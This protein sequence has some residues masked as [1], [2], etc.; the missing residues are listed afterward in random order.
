[1]SRHS[2][3]SS[4]VV[5]TFVL[6]ILASRGPVKHPKP[7]HEASNFGKVGPIDSS[8]ALTRDDSEPLRPRQEKA[9]DG[10]TAIDTFSYNG[11]AWTAYEDIARFD[12][13]LVLVSASGTRREIRRYVEATSVESLELNRTVRPF[14]DL[15]S[16]NDVN[17]KQNDVLAERLLQD[18]EPIEE[19]VRDVINMAYGPWDTFLGNVQ[20]NDTMTLDWQATTKNYMPLV[21][22]LEAADG[23]HS[24][25]T[26]DGL[27]GGW[28]PSSRKI[29]RGDVDTTD[30]IEVTTFADVDSPDPQIVHLWFSIKWIKGGVVRANRFALD[31]KQFLP[32]KAHPT[33]DDY[34]PALI[35]FADYWDSHLQDVATL[36]VPDKSWSDMNKHAF[37]T[38]LVQRAGGVSPRYGAFDRDYAG[39]EYDGFQD[40]MTTSLTANLAWGRF[41][42]AKAILENYMDWY[43]NDNGAIKM[44]G[45]AVPQFGMSLSLIARYVQYTGD[46]G[47]T[48]KYKTKILAWAN[49]LTERQDENLKFPE[50]HPYYGLISGWSESDAALRWDSWRWEKPYWNNGAFAARGLKDLSKIATFEQYAQDWQ[51]RAAQLINQT[52]HTLDA[53]IQRNLTTPY[54]PLLPNETTHVLEDLAEQGDASSQWWPHRVYTELLQASVL[55]PN[56]TDL[57]INSMQAYG[58]TSLG[59]VANVTPLRADTRDILGFISYGYALSLLLQDRLDEFVLFLYS[60]RYHVHNRGLWIAAEVSGTGGGSSTF[61]Q[62][63]Q[64]AVPILLRA[65]LLLDHPDEEVLFVG[66]GV[67]RRWL[68][69][70]RVAIQ[71]APTKWGLVDLDMQL[72]E[73][74]GSVTTVL[75]FERGPP[76]EVRVK[77]RV[78]EG[79][80]LK[81]VTVDGKAAEWQGEEVILRLGA[82]TKNVTVVGTF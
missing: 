57:V 52:S 71:K 82:S 79:R 58:I 15:D 11:E 34:Y 33:A 24:N 18:G 72:D 7:Y 62:P 53:V 30:W 41:P 4:L 49:M 43:V 74:A 40:I 9:A 78:P 3:K 1:M 45:P 19:H 29:F 61:C 70:G 39:S 27:L 35:R 46:V 48:E 16:A 37:A 59:V 26:F 75:G 50:D 55:S 73:K 80:E 68:S 69:K 20:A 22:V 23:T 60:H 76:A 2:L 65:A 12:G 21:D 47:F 14:F 42:Q 10:L 56:L 67:P 32:L 54:V 28:L 51:T 13:P 63:S 25:Y 31:Y 44:R 36:E 81:A 5:F 6:S 64:F 38:E 77:L 17:L 66:R 8:G